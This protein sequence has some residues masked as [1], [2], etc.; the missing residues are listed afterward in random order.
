MSAKKAKA[1]I[2]LLKLR[3][4]NLAEI[5]RAI[6]ISKQHFSHVLNGRRDGRCTW[7]K[8]RALL[9]EEERSAIVQEYGEVF[10]P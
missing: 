7:P 10:D 3:E 9:T 8:M 6:P 4:T 5:C 2:A 1:F